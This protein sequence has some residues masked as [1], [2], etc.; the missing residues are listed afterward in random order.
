MRPRTALLAIVSLVG[1]SVGQSYA[2]APSA[3]PPASSAP[4]SGNE[5][6]A[7]APNPY[8]ALIQQ[9]QAS[10]EKDSKAL[11]G[12][13]ENRQATRSVIQAIQSSDANTVAAFE[14]VLQELKGASAP[15]AVR[16]PA[17]A[18]APPSA[19]A[20]APAPAPAAS[21]SNEGSPSSAELRAAMQE[22]KELSQN[23]R[24]LL[25]RVVPQPTDK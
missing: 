13:I 6:P 5:P 24:D 1:L 9:I 25:S 2:Q 14:K 21:A 18:P 16:A 20:P 19:Q 10:Q 3:Y 12:M 22:I 23:V 8:L 4:S 7:A 11:R 17:P 15:A